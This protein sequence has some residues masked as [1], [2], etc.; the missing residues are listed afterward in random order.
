MVL[1]LSHAH[2][3]LCMKTLKSLL[4]TCFVVLNIINVSGQS[5]FPFAYIDSIEVVQSNK[6]LYDPWTGGFNS[7]QFSEIDLDKDGKKDLFVFDKQGNTIKTFLNIGTS[8]V[9]KYKYA[10]IYQQYFPKG[11]ESFALLA[12]FNNDG[13]EDIF[14]YRSSSMILHKNTTKYNIPDFEIYYDD[15]I[16]AKIFTNSNVYC[17]VN[18]IPALTDVDDDGDLDILVFH[19]QGA[20][21]DY[22]ENQTTDP[23]TMMLKRITDCWGAF[24]ESSTSDTI[25][26]GGCKRSS[27]SN[28]RHIGSTIS[29]I[30]LDGNGAKDI[31]LGD[32]GSSHLNALYNSG[33]NASAHM[34]SVEYGYPVAGTPVDMESFIATFLIDADNDGKKDLLV[35]PNDIEN[36]ND[37][38]N[39]WLYKNYGTTTDAHFVTPQKN[40]IVDGHIDHGT[41]SRPVFT[42]VD[43]DG[44]L[45]IVVG[46]LGYFKYYSG[47]LYAPQYEARLAFY[48]NVG[49]AA[50]PKFELITDD[51]GGLGVDSLRGAFPTFGDLDDDGDMDML[52][53]DIDG[54]IAYYKNNSGPSLTPNYTKITSNFFQIVGGP[55]A[56]PQLY[57]L[58]GDSLL[59]LIV[60]EKD[61][62][63][64][65]YLNTGTKSSPTFNNT[66]DKNKL[67]G[68]HIFK[69]GY[70]SAVAPFFTKM[71][72]T[73]KTYLFVGTNFGEIIVYDSIDGNTL[74]NYTPIDTISICGGSVT[75]TLGNIMGND[76]LELL[77]GQAAGG[78]TLFGVG[79][80]ELVE[81]TT[82]K[83]SSGIG[84]YG[85][86]LLEENVVIYPNPTQQVLN[87]EL[88]SMEGASVAIEIF[89]VIGRKILERPSFVS[90]SR[91]VEQFTM[92]ELKKGIYLV[93]IKSNKG[94]LVKKVLKN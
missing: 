29:L 35:A 68:I 75:P 54:K 7:P 93:V 50:L 69:P 82:L 46:G 66:P 21:V 67:G 20:K 13:K 78:L 42:D 2:I 41:A 40:F 76:S 48:R 26:L 5:K 65:L 45:D 70:H 73:N 56:V 79:D 84:I 3:C 12:D 1:Y 32:V 16:P 18:D 9:P 61:G 33:S 91:Q 34:N 83:D 60:G 31:I 71:D 28:S 25:V 49:T 63:M 89:D 72:S 37:I 43:G 64:K 53:G 80:Y 14:S 59:D 58:N 15:V 22:F 44:L 52:L 17:F 57:D 47:S 90:S 92:D 6:L 24:F 85:P 39:V 23:D 87:V 51:F 94:S 30:D 81:D 38:N 4:V 88:K 55:Y 86:E 19:L 62:Y 74:G 11:L 36:G 10:P 27:T 8:G 77:V